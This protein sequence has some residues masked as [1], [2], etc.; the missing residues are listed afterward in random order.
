MK[1]KEVVIGQCIY[2]SDE[3]GQLYFIPEK[4]K[5]HIIYGYSVYSPR[6]PSSMEDAANYH[7]LYKEATHL[8]ITSIP[9]IYDGQHKNDLLKLKNF[10]VAQK[11]SLQGLI[12]WVFTLKV[13]V[14][15]K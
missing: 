7:L 11:N 14:K 8:F 15:K 9:V 2:N 6:E 3:D 4:I 13:V 5:E 1:L 12:R 10:K